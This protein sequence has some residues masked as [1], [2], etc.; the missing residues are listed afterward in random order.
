MNRSW[1]RWHWVV[2]RLSEWLWNSVWN[3]LNFVI[4]WI[5]LKH[6]VEIRRTEQFYGVSGAENNTE[7]RTARQTEYH[8]TIETPEVYQPTAVYRGMRHRATEAP[9]QTTDDGHYSDVEMDTL[10]LTNQESTGDYDHYDIPTLPVYEGLVTNAEIHRPLPP[11][12]RVYDCLVR[13]LQKNETLPFNNVTLYTQ[14]TATYIRGPLYGNSVRS[15]NSRNFGL[16][17]W[18]P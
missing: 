11:P 16:G 9:S 10:S 14:C 13:W 15:R 8:P 6:F 18:N 1:W 7:R 5:F 12:P 4:S 3:I 2:F 17:I